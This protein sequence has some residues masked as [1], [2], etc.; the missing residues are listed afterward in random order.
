MT[1]L[2]RNVWRMGVLSIA[3]AGLPLFLE[4]QDD[5]SK[6][7]DEAVES[8]RKAQKIPGVSVAICRDG[9]IEK[10]TGYGLANVEW[11]EAVRPDTIFQTGSVG[12]QFTAT[13]VMMLVEEGKSRWTID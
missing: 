1:K 2:I 8:Q 5:R 7:A 10:A 6:R 11:N 13:A 4:A 9:K 3:V 12:K